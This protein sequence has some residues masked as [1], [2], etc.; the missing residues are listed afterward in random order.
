MIELHQFPRAFGVPNPSPF[1]M[2]VETY[3][4]LTRLEYEIVPL[5]DPSKAPKGKGPYIV[6]GDRTVADSHFILEY[7]KS[8]YGDPLSKGLDQRDRAHH[9]A[10][11][12]MMEEHLY[13]AIL[14]SRWLLPENAPRVRETFFA[15]L[16]PAV[17]GLVF[18]M[19]Q[20]NLAKTTK[21]Q[22]MGRHS[23]KEIERL[24]IQDLR[25]LSSVLRDRQFFGGEWPRTIDCVAY[26][27][28]CNVVEPPFESEVKTA[29]IGM[30]N[31]LEYNARMGQHVF[32]DL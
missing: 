32:P 9:H 19:V 25:A 13:F 16:H 1:C 26:S 31:L 2:K 14:Y 11:A 15:G 4:R 17:R 28:I 20:K 29:A 24:A 6:D 27:F 21:L 7:L 3:L 30:R 5:A 18:K 10:L 23:L 8:Q 22:G 12:R